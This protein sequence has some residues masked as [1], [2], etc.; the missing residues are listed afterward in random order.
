[1]ELLSCEAPPQKWKKSF[2]PSR[3]PSPPRKWRAR[4]GPPGGD[5]CLHAYKVLLRIRVESPGIRGHSRPRRSEAGRG[6]GRAPAPGVRSMGMEAG[7]RGGA[8]AL[9]K[10]MQDKRA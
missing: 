6:A 5:S 1:M 8:S 2:A 4:L 7:V 10:P 3:S 9:G